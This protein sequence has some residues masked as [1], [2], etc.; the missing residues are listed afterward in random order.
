VTDY[1]N[2]PRGEWSMKDSSGKLVLYKEGDQVSK[3]GFLYSAIKNTMGYSPEQGERAGWKKLNESRIMNFT[4]GD[5]APSNANLGDE[6]FDTSSGTLYKYI[7][8]EDTSQWIS[9]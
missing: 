8:D 6:W 9:L 1:I 5:T 4:S 7:I 3:D 2:N